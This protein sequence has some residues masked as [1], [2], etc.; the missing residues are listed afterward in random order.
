[1]S[2]SPSVSLTSADRSE[3]GEYG[4]DGGEGEGGAAASNQPPFPPVA[5]PCDEP[6]VSSFRAGRQASGKSSSSLGGGFSD[7]APPAAPPPVAAAAAAAA[8]PAPEPF[9]VASTVHVGGGGVQGAAWE[10][11]ARLMVRDCSRGVVGLEPPGE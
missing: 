10:L 1:M 2:P 5:F 7:A 11:R 6:P 3:R 4:V 9:E 8:P